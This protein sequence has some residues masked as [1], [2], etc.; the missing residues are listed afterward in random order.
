MQYAPGKVFF[1]Y[2]EYLEEPFLVFSDQFNRQ[3]TKKTSFHFE[4]Q[5]DYCQV[6]F[7]KLRVQVH[8]RKIE[9]GKSKGQVFMVLI[10]MKSRF[11]I[12]LRQEPIF[13][14]NQT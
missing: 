6:V 7:K 4:I 1:C 3:E 9:I 8:F 11:I 13:R 5:C 14:I 2:I 10:N 12:S